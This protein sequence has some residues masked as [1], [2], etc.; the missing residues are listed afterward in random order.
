MDLEGEVR[1]LQWRLCRVTATL[2]FVLNN[3]DLQVPPHMY[4]VILDPF[5]KCLNNLSDVLLD[6]NLAFACPTY[7]LPGE[8]ALSLSQTANRDVIICST[9]ESAFAVGLRILEDIIQQGGRHRA[10][11]LRHL[12]HVSRIFRFVDRLVH[13]KAIRDFVAALSS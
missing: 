2:Q 8:V 13:N 5:A 3:P 1:L 7:L 4:L 6:M 10:R 12:V 9:I 11:G